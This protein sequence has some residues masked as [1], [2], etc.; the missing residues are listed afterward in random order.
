MAWTIETVSDVAGFTEGPQWTGDVLLFVDMT[1]DRILSFDPVASSTDVLY[2]GTNSGNGLLWTGDGHLYCCESGARRI[3]RILADS[4]QSETVAE[5]FEGK[6][7][8]SPNDIISDSQGR[9]W[10]TDPRYGQDR[11]DMELEHESIYRLIREGTGWSMERMTFD[12]TRPNGLA[13]SPDEQTLYVAQSDYGEGA[14][15]ELRAYPILGNGKLGE[16]RVLHNFAPSR[17]A[18]GLKVTVDG[19]ILAAAGWVQDGPGPLLYVFEDSGRVVAT[20]SLG[21]DF[22]TNLCFGGDGLT[23]LYMTAGSGRLYCVQDCGYV[24]AAV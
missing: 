10:F 16:Y 3:S 22:P 19:L 5:H 12:T 6:R 13:L 18:D 17:G 9:L 23:D 2:Q 24:G 4:Q 20:H 8:N 1:T 21:N 11:H 7:L 15:R 14:K